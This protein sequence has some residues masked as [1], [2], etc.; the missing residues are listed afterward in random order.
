[1]I[2]CFNYCSNAEITNFPLSII[3][4]GNGTYL[5]KSLYTARNYEFFISIQDEFTSKI[6]TPKNIMETSMC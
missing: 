3:N 4:K 1:M 6:S 5:H 2:K